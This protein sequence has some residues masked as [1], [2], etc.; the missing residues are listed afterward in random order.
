[1]ELQVPAVSDEA[2]RRPGWQKRRYFPIG[3]PSLP[4]S[5]IVYHSARMITTLPERCQVPMTGTWHLASGTWHVAFAKAVLA[6]LGP[7]HLEVPRTGSTSATACV[8]IS[9]GHSG[10]SQPARGGEPGRR[11]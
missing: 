2:G 8:R 4:D 5:A 11:I 10:G 9:G 1:V 6:V 7:A 3:L